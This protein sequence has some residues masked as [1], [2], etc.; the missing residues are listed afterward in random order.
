MKK[1]AREGA[2]EQ[3][4]HVALEGLKQIADHLTANLFELE[5]ERKEL[6]GQERFELGR[7]AFEYVAVL[8]LNKYFA[9]LGEPPFKAG[10]W[11]GREL[12]KKRTRR[13]S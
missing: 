10:T 1:R 9:I 2:S 7:A 11:C 8:S 12:D 6:K 5:L 3:A 13:T 4:Y